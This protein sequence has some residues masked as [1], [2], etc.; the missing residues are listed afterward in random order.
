MNNSSYLV[1]AILNILAFILTVNVG[2]AQV[3]YRTDLVGEAEVPP[4][5]S[6]STGS[7]LIAG[8]DSSLKFQIN[9][10]SL[11]KVTSVSLYKGDDSE[12]GQVLV[13][14]LNSTE[15]SGL[16]EGK[17]VE[18]T[19]N[20]SSI[21]APLANLTTNVTLNLPSSGNLTNLR[22]T[23][24]APGNMSN[25]TSGFGNTTNLTTNS[26][27]MTSPAAP[28]SKLEALIDLMNQN[29]TYINIHTSQFPE[30]ELRGT[31]V[32]TNSTG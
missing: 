7:A 19:I 24:P 11:D 13:S 2:F 3:S 31:L 9:V 15:P 17:L 29:M 28:V 4:L 1:A 16:V 6:E 21:L 27:N 32:P 14:L 12:N 30:G 10:T 25:L 8:N 5:F 20:S 18:G 23:V 22:S 26:G